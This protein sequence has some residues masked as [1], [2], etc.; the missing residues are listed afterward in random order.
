MEKPVVHTDLLDEI[1]SLMAATGLSKPDF[2]RAV[3]NDPRLV[4]DMEQGRELRRATEAK[5]RE[6]MVALKASA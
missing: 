3:L 2:G 5:V 4:Y 6:K 1:T